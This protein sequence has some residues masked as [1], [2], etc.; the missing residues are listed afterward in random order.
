MVRNYIILIS[1]IVTRL[2]FEFAGFAAWNCVDLVSLPR[3]HYSCL[4][5][6]PIFELASTALTVFKW[7]NLYIFFLSL[8]L[9]YLDG[10]AVAINELT[11]PFLGVNTLL[12]FKI[13]L[14]E[15]GLGFDFFFGGREGRSLGLTYVDLAFLSY[16]ML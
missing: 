7:M 13:K 8:Y 16:F 15:L 4:F 11:F 6:R 3:V 14:L 10:W 12:R 9:W 2:V 1:T 5:C